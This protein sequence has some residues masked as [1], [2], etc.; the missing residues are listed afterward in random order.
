MSDVFS[1]IFTMEGGWL[2]VEVHLGELERKVL[3]LVDDLSGGVIDAFVKGPDVIETGFK[4]SGVCG[5]MIGVDIF[6]EY[7]VVIGE[8]IADEWQLIFQL[9]RNYWI[10]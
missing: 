2:W 7:G 8:A 4:E 10:L 5:V 6:I 3:L 9:H 1:S